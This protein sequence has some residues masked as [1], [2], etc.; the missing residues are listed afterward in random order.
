MY[1]RRFKSYKISYGHPANIF[2][3]EI[4]SPEDISRLYVRCLFT[5]PQDILRMYEDYKQISSG[6]FLYPCRTS[7]GDPKDVRV[8]FGSSLLVLFRSGILTQHIEESTIPLICPFGKK[9]EIG[10]ACEYPGS[11]VNFFIIRIVF[12]TKY[13][14]N[15]RPRNR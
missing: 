11:E 13:R 7:L 8:L 12:F 4:E 6:Y 9:K 15:S 1:C 10:E 2:R 5:I 14:R 3:T